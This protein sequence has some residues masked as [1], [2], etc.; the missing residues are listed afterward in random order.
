[1]KKIY[2][3]IILI[4]IIFGLVFFLN[5]FKAVGGSNK[6]EIFTVEDYGNSDDVVS[7]KL[8]EA[9]YIKS[10]L[11]FDIA[12]II[13]NKKNKIQPGGYYI[14]KNMDT[15]K[16][17]DLMTKGPDLKWI[18]LREGLRKEQ[19]GERLKNTFGWS[20]IELEKWNTIYTTKNPDY[21][22]GVYFPDTYL[23]PVSENGQ[24]IADRMISHFN[25]KFAPY[26]K[27]AAEKNI[28]WTTALR[29]AS[30]IQR[31][32]GSVTDMSLIS[33]VIWNRLENGEK[34]D[35]DATIQYAKGKTDGQW[36]SVVT[37]DDIKNID[38]PYNT[39]KYKGLPPHPISNPGIS[40]INAAINPA[41]TDCIFYLHDHNRQIH[42]SKTYEQHLENIKKYLN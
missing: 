31:E 35:I 40:A 15:W 7:L 3:F 19:I 12:I 28:K 8:Q 21:T 17:I 24:Q 34:L 41:D 32:A 22:E 18:K 27:E 9:G 10:F 5:P 2:V 20:D 30:L 25:E 14:S 36:W 38:S 23:I 13:K 33:G 42:C 29:I 39:Y 16:I 4:F 26:A 6:I 11:I 37:G 1:M